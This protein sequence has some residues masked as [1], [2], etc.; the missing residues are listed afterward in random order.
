MSYRRRLIGCTIGALMIATG[1]TFDAGAAPRAATGD[2]CRGLS[3]ASAQGCTADQLRAAVGDRA[4][5]RGG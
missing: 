2:G 4:G 1:A 5:A 3:P